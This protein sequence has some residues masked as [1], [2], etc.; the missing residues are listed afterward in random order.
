MT[1]QGI[2]RVVD[3][4]WS[5]AEENNDTVNPIV[6]LGNTYTSHT[7]SP[8]E[9]AVP[10]T[11]ITTSDPTSETE[12]ERGPDSSLT[13]IS[14][15]DI[16]NFFSSFSV[17]KE[18]PKEEPATW[19]DDFLDDV[20]SRLWFTYRTKFPP[21]Q[22]DEDGPSPLSLQNLI[23][24]HNY[25]L[26]ADFF[27]SDCGWGCMIRTGQ[28]MLANALLIMK[29][30]RT[31][32]FDEGS[33]NN[34]THDEIVSY[35]ADD[36]SR[37]FSIHNIVDQGR[38]LSGK[39]AGEWFGPSAIA[40]SMQ[41]LCEQHDVGLR[42]YIGSD[43]GDVYEQDVF[44]VSRGSGEDFQPT[45][46]LLGV[47]LGIDQVNQVYWKSLKDILSSY[48]SVGIAGGRPS[49]SH[50][51]F[52]YQGDN[53][54]CLDPHI[55]QTALKYVDM[56]N[57]V[58]DSTEIISALDTK[59]VHTCKVRRIHFSELDPSMLVGFL[60]KNGEDWESWKTSIQDPE[61][62][63]AIVHISPN[64]NPVSLTKN[65]QPSFV[66]VNDE[67]GDDF[68]D[69]GL[70]YDDIPEESQSFT[71]SATIKS[72]GTTAVHA[73]EAGDENES[74]V[75]VPEDSDGQPCSSEDPVEVKNTLMSRD[76][77]ASFDY[78]SNSGGSIKDDYENIPTAPTEKFDD[79][80]TVEIQSSQIPDDPFIVVKS[81][82][83][84]GE[85]TDLVSPNEETLSTPE[86]IDKGPIEAP[87][88]AAEI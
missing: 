86:V 19:P 76:T 45:L 82:V 14:V 74:L 27:T 7:R 52:G 48:Q 81:D 55:P 66:I 6:V 42:V 60:I 64:H 62:K 29:A 20:N 11:G 75:I 50:Y 28:S 77:S 5:R 34:K 3:M 17:S 84:E 32:R 73:S 44:K 69:V 87:R 21:L 37:P 80:N 8:I 46:I 61:N 71:A 16:R 59:S 15:S 24:G 65:R 67:G 88:A 85:D 38:A 25:H 2:H 70:E 79:T 63:N 39:K 41:A 12:Q 40:R 54:F 36:P 57:S 30:G 10:A 49:S 47:R 56:E 4:F 51:F 83:K 43:S 58:S 22:R 1:S 31:W 9:E 53:L 72:E 13:E 33:T 23:R 35:F 78:F 68:I 26:N 18:Q